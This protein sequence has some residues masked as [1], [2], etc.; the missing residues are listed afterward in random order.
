MLGLWGAPFL[1]LSQQ[2][3]WEEEPGQQL[4]LP[5]PCLRGAS[6]P[7]SPGACIP[8]GKG[9]LQV[10]AGLKF[11]CAQAALQSFSAPLPG[12]QAGNLQMHE[13]AESCQHH[14]LAGSVQGILSM[15]KSGHLQPAPWAQQGLQGCRFC[16]MLQTQYFSMALSWEALLAV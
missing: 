5:L 2:N 7:S 10:A 9:P 6:T 1:L 8:I 11:P 3:P 14:S 12:C 13:Q 4:E 16:P 15:E